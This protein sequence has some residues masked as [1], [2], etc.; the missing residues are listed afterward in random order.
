MCG[1]GLQL[2][3]VKDGVMYQCNRAKFF[4]NPKLAAILMSTADAHIAEDAPGDAYWG[5]GGD[6][7]SGTSGLNKLGHILVRIRQELA[8]DTATNTA[9]VAA[10]PTAA[11][12]QSQSQSQ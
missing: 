4:Q 8:K 10:K 9:T 6:G 12:S 1:A 11:Q 5:D 3:S 2:Q 7:G